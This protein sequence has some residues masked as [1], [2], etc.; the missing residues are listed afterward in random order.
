MYR[1]RSAWATV[2]AAASVLAFAALPARAGALA[3]A[4]GRYLILPSSVVDFTVAQIGGGGI[5]GRFPDFS[6]R[7]DIDAAD[8]SKSEVEITL[9]PGSLVTAEPRITKFLKSSAVFDVADYPVVRFRSFRVERTGADTARIEGFLT[10]R[11][12]TLQ[13]SFDARLTRRSAGGIVFHVTGGIY[14]EP[15]GM[16]VGVPIYSNVVRFDMTLD[17]RRERRPLAATAPRP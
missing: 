17:A 4:A 14:R 6:G 7:F 8:L 11:G 13:E 2:A 3:D 15:Y 5:V 9:R 1:A 16:G 12:K 10:A